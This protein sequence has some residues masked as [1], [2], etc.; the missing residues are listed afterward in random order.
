MLLNRNY[1]VELRL[2]DP[3]S[4]EDNLG[5]IVVDLCLMYRDATIK[6]N[7]VRRVPS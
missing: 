7:P 4:K 2:D 5:S 3:K 6:R 1:E